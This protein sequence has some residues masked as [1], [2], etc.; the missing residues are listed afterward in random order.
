MLL[1]KRWCGNTLDVDGNGDNYGIMKGDG[2]DGNDIDCTSEFL[3]GLQMRRMKMLMTL[4]LTT[5][6]TIHC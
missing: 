5:T 4:P 2:N 3:Q 1:R 6:R